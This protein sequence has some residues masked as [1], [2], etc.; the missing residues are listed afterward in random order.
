M[1]GGCDQATKNN[2]RHLTSNLRGI[3]AVE[4][5]MS[6]WTGRL[7]R[8][9]E[10]NPITLFTKHNVAELQF[11]DKQCAHVAGMVYFMDLNPENRGQRLNSVYC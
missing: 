10:T 7:E 5:S 4:C 9:I 11:K 1:A 8:V 3:D 2:K 6:W